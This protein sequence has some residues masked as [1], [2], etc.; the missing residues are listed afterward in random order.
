[1]FYVV[2][3]NKYKIWRLFME[4]KKKSVGQL[5]PPLCFEIFFYMLAG[6][7]DT[8]ML[9]SVGDDAVGAV[10]AVTLEF[11]SPAVFVP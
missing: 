10:G 3:C 5:F 8:L 11:A 2:K 1:M 4:V 9:S 6:M 7:V